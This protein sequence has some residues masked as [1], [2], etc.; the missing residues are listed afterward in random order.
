M[1][2]LWGL[3]WSAR[4]FPSEIKLFTS[5]YML[6]IK[7]LLIF[8]VAYNAEKTISK[9]LTR[10]PVSLLENFDM[11]VLVIDDASTDNTFRAG[12]NAKEVLSLPFP[13][14][15]LKKPPHKRNYF[16]IKILLFYFQYNLN[17]ISLY[18]IN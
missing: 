16:L 9:I 12:L 13:I 14:T 4:H 2:A 5:I 11:E 18:F 7:R 10:I 1:I 8:V 17:K 3:D 6:N 15:I